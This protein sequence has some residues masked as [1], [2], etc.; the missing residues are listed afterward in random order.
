MKTQTVSPKYCTSP[1]I[2]A[3]QP[4]KL[5]RWGGA[6]SGGTVALTPRGEEALQKL[7]QT[8]GI[9]ASPGV[10]GLLSVRTPWVEALLHALT[11]QL[12][13]QGMPVTEET[14]NAAHSATFAK[15][16]SDAVISFPRATPIGRKQG[17]EIAK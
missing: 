6:K 11:L 16:I 7:L 1:A 12:A 2:P 14:L 15:L 8:A 13:L 17:N 10:T 5:L 4:L 3:Y 9:P